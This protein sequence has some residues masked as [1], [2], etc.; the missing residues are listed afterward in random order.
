MHRAIVTG[1]ITGNPIT[2]IVPTITPA[3]IGDGA[4]MVDRTT[5]TIRRDIADGVTTVGQDIAVGD[6]DTD[7]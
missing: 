3:R 5:E 1:T 7:F 4:I 2:T 6:V